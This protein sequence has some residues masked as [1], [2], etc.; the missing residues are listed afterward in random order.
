[1][2]EFPIVT[3]VKLEQPENACSPIEVTESPKTIDVIEEGK[4]D[5]KI[6]TQ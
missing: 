6:E 4:I 5:L 2:T 3:E 1:M